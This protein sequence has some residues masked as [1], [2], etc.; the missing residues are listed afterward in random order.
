MGTRRSCPKEA[1]N[2]NVDPIEIRNKRERKVLEVIKEIREPRRSM[3]ESAKN[4]RRENATEHLKSTFS[5]PR[6]VNLLKLTSGPRSPSLCSC[7]QL[8][9]M[10]NL[11]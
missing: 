7:A 2:L 9:K 8:T 1:R 4:N 11:Q 5:L 10:E 6:I 3:L